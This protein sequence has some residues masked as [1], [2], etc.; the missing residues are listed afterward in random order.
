MLPNTIANLSNN[1]YEQVWIVGDEV[2][3]AVGSLVSLR[4]NAPIAAAETYWNA[5]HLLAR[6]DAM[7]ADGIDHSMRS[8]LLQWRPPADLT[9]NP[10]DALD[11]MTWA[12]GE[13]VRSIGAPPDV[14][15]RYRRKA[16]ELHNRLPG[17]LARTQIQPIY[18]TEHDVINRVYDRLEKRYGLQRP[19]IENTLFRNLRGFINDISKQPGR[20][21]NQAELEFELRSVWP[22]MIA[23][24][25]AP[26]LDPNHIARPDLAERF[27]T[28]WT[29][30]AIETVGISGSGKTMLAAEVAEKSRATDP[31]R[32]VYYAE[33]RPGVS[34][35][36]VLVGLAYHLRRI[37]IEEPFSLSVDSRLT[38][39]EVLAR[40]ARSYSA[41]AQQILLLVDLV[42]G[43]SDTAFARTL[44]PL[45]GHSHPPRAGLPSSGRK[46]PCASLLSWKERSLVRAGWMSAASAL[47]N[48]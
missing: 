5:I 37:G 14:T 26:P 7:N 28:R 12:F 6:N 2:N 34:L 24:K 23:V 13:H 21:F 36:D 1:N 43:T 46:A 44:P 8:R 22:H 45:F 15:D 11:A 20:S 48:L 35:R 10:A 25:D 3:D 9:A 17:I 18:G 30:K 29:G 4:E 32:Q 39:E 40:L 41:V 47:M 16:T 42:E 33:V 38:R 19:V 27:T 31:D